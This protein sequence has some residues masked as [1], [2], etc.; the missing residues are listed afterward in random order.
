MYQLRCTKTEV[1]SQKNIITFFGWYFGTEAFFNQP[2]FIL[3][4]LRYTT[5]LEVEKGA[6][7]Q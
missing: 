4:F 5:A 6:P 3:Y 7:K 2:M 1:C